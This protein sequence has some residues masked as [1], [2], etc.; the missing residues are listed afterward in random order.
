V[1]AV[2]ALTTGTILLGRA[3]ARTRIER[4]R[5]A[6]QRDRA[7]DRYR[8]ARTAVDESFNTISESKLLRRSGMQPLRKE[9]LEASLRYYQFFLRDP[10]DDPGL[11]ADVAETYRRVAYLNDQ[12]GSPEDALAAYR[13]AVDLYEEVL[14]AGRTHEKP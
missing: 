14:Q 1:A 3:N 4:D 7:R 12:I 2:I 8:L 9:L 6:E 11:R 13:K 5:A 10:D